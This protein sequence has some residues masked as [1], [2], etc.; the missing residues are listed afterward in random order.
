MAKKGSYNGPFF[1]TFA[2]R[3]YGTPIRFGLLIGTEATEGCRDVLFA[4]VTPAPPG[5][6]GQTAP[7]LPKDVATLLKSTQNGTTYVDW[8]CQ[9][10]SAI[11]KLLPGGLEPCGC[12][13]VATEATARDLAPVLAPILRKIQEAL[14]LTLDPLTRKLTF[15][16]YVGGA[17]PAL[18]PA[19]MKSDSFKDAVVLWAAVPLDVIAPC[20]RRDDGFNREDV[21]ADLE[22]RLQE[23]V[24][25]WTL[26]VGDGSSPMQ[27]VDPAS[28]VPIA[29]VAQ[30]VRELRAALLRP[31]TMLLTLPSAETRPLLRHRCFVVAM[32]LIHRPTIELR[33]ATGLLQKEI[34]SSAIAR[35]QLALDEADG[36]LKGRLSLPWRAFFRSRDIGLPVW[37]GDY[38]MPDEEPAAGADRI[39]QLLGLPATSLLPAP[40]H[41]NEHERLQLE[42]Q[43]TY[44]PEEVCQAKESF[45]VDN[46]LSNLACAAALAVGL[47]AICLPIFLGIKL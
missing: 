12:F 41:L 45:K 5:P 25:G 32:A 19:Q 28:D 11:Q 40:P 20:Q 24:A 7:P 18:R 47:A 31:G 16:Q 46:N 10:A 33:Y 39:G 42:H 22:R 34:I 43:G 21:V 44:S 27:V 26:A 6:E 35:L 30:E 4:A 29:S 23:S 14:V 15:W 38:C 2:E 17:K 37:F 8:A 1:N 3:I 13:A 36:E 9:H